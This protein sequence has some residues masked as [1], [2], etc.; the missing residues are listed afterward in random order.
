MGDDVKRRKGEKQG[1][2]GSWKRGGLK[3]RLDVP[4]TLEHVL[5]RAAADDDFRRELIDT[6]VEA[7]ARAGMRLTGSE[8]ALVRSLSPDALAAMIRNLNPERQRNK[9]FARAVATAAMVG[10]MLVASCD[11]NDTDA[12][13]GGAAPDIDVDS[14]TDGDTD[15]DTDGDTDADTD[16][17]T[18]TDTGSDTGTD[19]SSDTS[20]GE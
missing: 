4:V 10:G 14:D 5:L 8:A 2:V 18:D 12:K 17:D 19:T 6:P 3:A 20:T 1:L 11:S 9:R 7:I 13:A 15:T 16:T